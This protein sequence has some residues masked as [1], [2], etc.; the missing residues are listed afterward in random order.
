[1]KK[2]FFKRAAALALA[3]T[4][5]AAAAGCANNTGSSSTGSVAEASGAQSQAAG[6]KTKVVFWYMWGGDEGKVIDAAVKDYNQQSDKYEVESLSVP[7]S[8]KIMT[9]ISAGNG[10]DV[11]DDF[12]SNIGKFAGSGY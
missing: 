9:A 7:D 3:L 6:P 1:M 8:Q 5:A 10:P 12:S 2:K 4:M 11:S